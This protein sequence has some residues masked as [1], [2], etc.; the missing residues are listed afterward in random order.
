VICHRALDPSGPGVS[1]LQRDGE[2][3]WGWV[4]FIEDWRGG[5]TG[6]AHP[7]C[8]ADAHGVERLVEVV[9]ARDRRERGRGGSK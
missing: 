2:T 3:T 1:Q 5:R 6:F 7:L 8:F 4:A 9:H